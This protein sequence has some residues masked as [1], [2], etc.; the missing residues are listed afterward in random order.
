MLDE[1]NEF[2]TD[3]VRQCV[4]LPERVGERLADIVTDDDT[5]TDEV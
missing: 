3:A 4:G 1:D 5:L 2:V